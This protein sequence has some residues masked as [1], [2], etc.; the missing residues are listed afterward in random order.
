[1]KNHRLLY[2][3][4]VILVL[5][6]LGWWL[7]VSN[8]VPPAEPSV[9]AAPANSAGTTPPRGTGSQFG[10]AKANPSSVPP[11]ALPLEQNPKVMAMRAM[12]AAENSKPLDFYG[13]VVDQHNM[14]I[15][16]VQVKA[17]V[18]LI[19]SFDSSAGRFYDTET[20]ATGRFHFVGLHG[21]G[22]GPFI[23]HKE[24][25]FFD[26][27]LP[28]S[29]RP[30]DYI[31]DPNNPVIFRMWKLRGAESMVHAKFGAWIP[32]DGTP[33]TIDL[34]T[35]RKSD[36][37]DLKVSLVRHPLQ[38]RLG[39]D[40]FA[41]EVQFREVGGGLVEAN[42][43]YPYEA[44]EI[45]YQPMLEFGQAKDVPNWTRK[46]LQ[47]FYVHTAKGNY[48]RI[49]VDLTTD[50]D[51]AEGTGLS[52]E[53]WMNPSGSRNLEFDPAKVVRSTP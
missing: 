21:A 4:L 11:Q 18:G 43:P 8:E 40:H 23:L 16:N 39:V 38:V 42:N 33:V 48:G 34:F 13:Q 49:S 14:P 12:V 29:S 30:K 2:V 15:A 44:P 1:M 25:F 24:G 9:N 10:A 36:A 46:L 47:T 32:Y 19:V 53:T 3:I 45:G 28:S 26:Q 7:W 31:A 52:V 37:G 50:S 17:G 20:D 41:W 6:G 35:G 27:H 5:G 22:M 51:R